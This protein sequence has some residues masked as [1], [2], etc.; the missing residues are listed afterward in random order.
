MTSYRSAVAIAIIAIIAQAAGYS[1]MIA[2][3]IASCSYRVTIYNNI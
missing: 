2:I 3:I 1:D